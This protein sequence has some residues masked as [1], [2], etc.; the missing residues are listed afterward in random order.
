M[1]ST[2]TNPAE[3]GVTAG[4]QGPVV[5]KEMVQEVGLNQITGSSFVVRPQVR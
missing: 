2:L 4:P 1:L 5:L 3:I